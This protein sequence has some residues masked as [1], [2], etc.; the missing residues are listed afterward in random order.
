MGRF[1]YALA[2]ICF[3]AAQGF[4]QNVAGN[5]YAD[6]NV[7][8]KCHADIA[9][10]YALTGMARSFYKPS[11]RN[12]VEPYATKPEYYHTLSDSHY[13]MTVRNG[14]YFQ[15]RWQ[16]GLDGK[17]I[18]AEEVKIDYVIGSGNHGRF[19]LH[20]TEGGVMF[21]LPLGWYSQK[22]GEW[23]MVPGSDLKRPRTRRFITDKCVF[24][25]NAYPKSITGTEAPNDLV[26]T[27]ELP[28]GIDCQRCHGPGAEHVR[29][30]GRGAIVNPVKL[31]PA[32]RLEV[33]LQCHLETTGGHIP[34]TLQRFDRGT[35][36]F[37]P[38]QKLSDYALFFDYAP[39]SGREERFEGVGG[40]YR[41]LQSRCVRESAGKLDCVS[42]HDPHD[43]PRGAEATRRYSA[44]C[45]RCH[46]S[47][48]HPKAVMA[49][50]E[51][52][53]SCH[54]PKRRSENAPHIV[55]TD[56][57]IQ[58]R[59]PANAL[60][61]FDEAPI[62]EYRGVVAPFYPSPFPSDGESELYRAVAQVGLGNNVTGGMP[63]LIRLMG[64]WKPRDPEFYMVLGDGWKSEGRFT[65]AANAYEAALHRK[66]DLVRAIRS[67]ASVQPD[68]AGA[69]LARAVQ[70][71]PNDPETWFQY[72]N[73]T[74]DP[75]MIQ[76]AI[77]LNPWLPDQSRRLAEMTHLVPALQDALR[78]D[79]FDDAAWNLGGRILTEK[80]DFR[81]ACFS[82]ERAIRIS[83]RAQYFYDYALALVRF[84]RFED[85]QKYASLAVA[86][87][88]SLAEAHELLGGL[89][90]RKKEW[91]E[92]GREYR[93]ELRLLPELGRVQLR[94]ARV[95]IAL[96]D[97]EGAVGLLRKAS[98][99]SDAE[100]ARQAR[101]VLGS[102]G[103]GGN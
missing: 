78:T 43:I 17:E 76:K 13:S 62:E 80:G 20:R 48:Q 97:R 12:T 92:A 81:E 63:D 72:G 60:A 42:C 11:P 50:R 21:E 73:L 33:C 74:S 102:M 19:Y 54:M 98:A 49:T 40:A 83:P 10:K 52:C 8:A 15:K 94:L 68:R 91:V 46:A 24:C 39:G 103:Y 64:E 3:A 90:S 37:V 51:D 65:E 88:S 93:E 16:M 38:G 84:D 100:V 82:F 71:A 70:I 6:S 47:P 36:S 66:P 30:M 67:L 7:C 41:F 96:G 28:Q 59:A 75:K 25:H 61:E 55:M 85:A 57:L 14:E 99:G 56:H 77:V 58:R 23:G 53:I 22:G 2:V 101:D 32:R 1:G 4:G 18:N 26:F 35:F 31:S 89:Y 5:S 29:T 27:G 95:L 45:V 44:V 86:Q 87:D 79:P 34:A 9:A 69:L